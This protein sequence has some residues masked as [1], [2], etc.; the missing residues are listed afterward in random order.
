MLGMGLKQLS[1]A[2]GPPLANCI[3]WLR[4]D[5]G[6]QLSGVTVS[7]WYDQSGVAG[8]NYLLPNNNPPTQIAHNASYNNQ[9]TIHFS[10]SGSSQ[11]LLSANSVVIPN[12]NTTIFVANGDGTANAQLFMNGNLGFG[13]GAGNGANNTVEMFGNSTNQFGTLPSGTNATP[14]V[15]AG[16]WVNGGNSAVYANNSQTSLNS[17]SIGAGGSTA[18]ITVGSGGGANFLNGN[19]AEIISYGVDL[20]SAQLKTVFQYLGSR[21]GIAVS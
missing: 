8:A 11:D 18:T 2:G 4:A 16:V 19:I 20:S 7:R 13:F 12:S 3:L 17:S 10:T 1:N 21:Y 14:F 15:Y 9:P 6:V 5:L